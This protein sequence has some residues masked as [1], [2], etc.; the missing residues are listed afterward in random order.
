MSLA[1]YR[2]IEVH[3]NMAD[4]E[5]TQKKTGEGLTDSQKREIVSEFNK[6]SQQIRDA[7]DPPLNVPDLNVPDITNLADRVNSVVESADIPAELI[8]GSI[9]AWKKAFQNADSA[10]TKVRSHHK[11]VGESIERAIDIE[12]KLDEL[13]RAHIIKSAVPDKTIK[14][15]IL[16]DSLGYMEKAKILY[17]GKIIQTEVYN[18]VKRVGELRNVLAHNIVREKYLNDIKSLVGS[19]DNISSLEDLE[20]DF[21]E[22]Y[23]SALEGLEN[24][25]T[26][27]IQT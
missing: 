5:K 4:K 10:F 3:K 24:T 21:R 18:D 2:D 1:K 25:D 8:E 15:N 20:E 27:K 11:F 19:I 14:K 22:F 6:S 23:I 16:T 12:E 9:E 7:F 26:C 13:I 17:K